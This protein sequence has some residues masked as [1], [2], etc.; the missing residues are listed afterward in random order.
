MKVKLFEHSTVKA[1]H[2]QISS[3]LGGEVAILD[4]DAGMYYGLDKVGARIWELVQEPRGVEKVQAIVLEEYE[5]DSAR[6]KH[7]VLALL[8]ELVDEGLVEAE[9]NT[10]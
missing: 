1:N 2:S 8:Q 5:V 3:D 6:G 4:L 9:G 10:H 7:D